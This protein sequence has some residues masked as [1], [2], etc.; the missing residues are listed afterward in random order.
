MT[1]PIFQLDENRWGR[2]IVMYSRTK[3]LVVAHLCFWKLPR[4]GADEDFVLVR[5]GCENDI[6][7]ATPKRLQLVQ[8]LGCGSNGV[9][10]EESSAFQADYSHA[11]IH[12]H[13]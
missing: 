12:L 11:D 7:D 6:L 2:L 13:I 1:Y 5:R 4:E 10:D 8:A 3:S 9:V